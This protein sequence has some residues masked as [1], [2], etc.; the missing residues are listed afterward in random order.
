MNLQLRILRHS[1]LPRE[2]SGSPD[3]IRD[4]YGFANNFGAEQEEEAD[5]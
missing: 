3:R 1:I 4:T 2:E 5:F